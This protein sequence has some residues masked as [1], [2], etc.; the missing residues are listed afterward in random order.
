MFLSNCSCHLYADDTVLY[1]TADSIKEALENLQRS[2]NVL[3]DALVGLRLMLNVSKTKFM[4]FSRS[5]NICYNDLRI[6]SMNGAD[7][8][9]VTEYKYLGIWIDEK[10]TFKHHVEVLA[11]KRRQKIGFLYIEIKLAFQ[12]S[13]GKELLKQCSCLFWT[14]ET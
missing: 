14:M 11:G 7:I 6:T 5:K 12:S 9:R 8:E 3:Q 2:F 10:L 4:L 1:C 13:A